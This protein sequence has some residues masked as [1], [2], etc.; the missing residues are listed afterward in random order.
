MD[1]PGPGA[2]LGAIF[3]QAVSNSTQPDT[4]VADVETT[5]DIVVGE[6]RAASQAGAARSVSDF[7]SLPAGFILL[8][9]IIISFVP[10]YLE[11]CHVGSS[12]TLSEWTLAIQVGCGYCNVSR[13]I[14]RF[15]G[16]EESDLI[17]CDGWNAV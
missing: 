12:H 6:C 5:G 3:L 13:C 7:P 8:V 15:E 11:V 4:C 9:G 16:K 1:L 2:E 10:Q 17:G 14:T